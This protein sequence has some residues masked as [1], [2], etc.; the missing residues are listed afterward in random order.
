MVRAKAAML[1]APYIIT[2]CIK[3]INSTSETKK[4]QKK[5]QYMF[6]LSV[7][8]S[9]RGVWGT[10]HELRRGWLAYHRTAAIAATSMTVKRDV[11]PQIA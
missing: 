4:Q 2:P 6:Y 8:C 1:I 11:V 10:A 3:M 7:G 9:R 5:K